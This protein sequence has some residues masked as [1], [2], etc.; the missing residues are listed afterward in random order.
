[1]PG[2]VLG[3]EQIR[4]NPCSVE[5]KGQVRWIKRDKYI[6]QIVCRK[7]RG[8]GDKSNLTEAGGSWHAGWSCDVQ[9]AGRESSLR[10]WEPSKDPKVRRVV[11]TV[12]T[13]EPGPGTLHDPQAGVGVR[14][15][16]RLSRGR[17]G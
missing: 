12:G 11:K 13:R 9:Q 1:M 17:E 7:R 10:R 16:G 3:N 6:K 15:A 2:C 14:T 8:Q 5:L 4:Q